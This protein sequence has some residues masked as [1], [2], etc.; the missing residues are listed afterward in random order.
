MSL[1][2]VYRVCIGSFNRVETRLAF[3]GA[4]KE[5]SEI[6]S[7]SANEPSVHKHASKLWQ[8]LIVSEVMIEYLI[9]N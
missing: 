3:E 1:L 6:L 9:E 8:V 5:V 7:Q 4:K 2:E